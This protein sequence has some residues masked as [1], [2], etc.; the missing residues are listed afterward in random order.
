MQMRARSRRIPVVISQGDKFG[1]VGKWAR[2]RT[3]ALLE[4]APFQG[5]PACR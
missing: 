3:R 5:G 4:I 2:K 1:R